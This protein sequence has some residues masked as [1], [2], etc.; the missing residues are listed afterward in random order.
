[1]NMMLAAHALGLG[2]CPT[3][4]FSQA[5]VRAVL[6]LPAHAVPEFLLQLGHRPPAKSTNRRGAKRRAGR[7]TD[8]IVFW[9]EYDRR[10]GPDG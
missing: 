10:E 4:S 1:M 6:E 3:T 2:S 9:E 7:S 5:G 8:E